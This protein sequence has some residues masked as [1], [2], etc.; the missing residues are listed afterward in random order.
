MAAIL[1][2]CQCVNPKDE[3]SSVFAQLEPKSEYSESE[4]RNIPGKLVPIIGTQFQ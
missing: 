2:R 1:S 4:Y 3:S